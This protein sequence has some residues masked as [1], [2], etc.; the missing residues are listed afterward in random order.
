MKAATGFN[1]V[2]RLIRQKMVVCT[3]AWGCGAFCG[4]EEIK[5]IIQWIACSIA[6]RDMMF[7]SFDARKALEFTLLVQQIKLFGLN[8]ADLL[9]IL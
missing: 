6:K 8:V 2:D 3:G 7:I 4:D 5:F 9:T 1:S